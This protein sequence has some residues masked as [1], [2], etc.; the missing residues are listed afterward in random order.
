[1]S[2]YLTLVITAS[3]FCTLV[4]SLLNEKGAGK[5]AK[6]VINI[7]MLCVIIMPIIKSLSSFSNNLAIPVIKDNNAHIIDNKE[8]DTRLYREWL[9]KT[10]ASQL[11][12]N[13]QSSVK[14]GTGFDVRVECP[15]HF[16]GNNVVFDKI[17]IYTASDKRY[18]ES[19]INYVKLHFS[20]DS[21]CL[22]EVE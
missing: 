7:V 17:K 4:S 18:F 5:T 22:R 14:E 11:S 3:F 12:E 6:A 20:L 10:T 8:D 13:I 16:E 19:I 1:M 9:A 21:E 15:W 2:N